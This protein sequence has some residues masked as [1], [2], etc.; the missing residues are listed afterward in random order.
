MKRLKKERNENKPLVFYQ[1]DR[2]GYHPI[3]QEEPAN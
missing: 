1:L 3:Q 2:A